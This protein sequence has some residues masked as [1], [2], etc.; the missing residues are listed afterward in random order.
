MER[1]EPTR[2]KRSSLTVI[3]FVAFVDLVGFGL[4]IP[5]QG[6]YTERLGATSLTFGFLVGVYA[7]AQIIFNP[8]LGRWSDRIG[9]RPVLL[10]SIAG[11]V[12]SHTLLGFADL[13]DS[14]PLLFAARILDG[15]TG[16]NV[17]TAQAYIADVTTHE[18]RARGMGLFGAAFGAGFVIGPAIGALLSVIGHWVT[19]PE[20]ATAWPAFG[21]A[22]I[23][24][25]ALVLVWR[26]LPEPERHAEQRAPALAIFTRSGWHRIAQT[27]Q[28]RELFTCLFGVTCAFVML[29]VTLVYL[30]MNRF[31]VG[32]RGVGMIFAYFGVLMIIVQGGLVG[33]LVKRYGEAKLLAIA[34][35]LT[36]GGFLLIAAVFSVNDTTWAWVLLLAGCVP[37]SV[38]HGLTGPN[39]NALISKSVSAGDQGGTFGAS[40]GVASLARAVAPPIGGLLYG[41]GPALPYWFGAALLVATALL[42][43]VTNKTTPALRP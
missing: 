42:V 19:G 5:L 12:V 38:G 20:H 16:A 35:I 6:V 2:M 37:T 11:S 13:A 17:A 23:S 8:I 7:V 25:T 24:F 41:W 18:N 39:I 40:Q 10:I 43:I 3:L 31:D 33:R 30:C 28:L 22:C 15:I 4:I 29:E 36:A 21:A 32:E 14:L 9:R 27:T 26:W 1:I 34:P